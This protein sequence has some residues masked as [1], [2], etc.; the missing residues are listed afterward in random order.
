MG[1][2]KTV[3]RRRLGTL[4]DLMEGTYGAMKRSVEDRIS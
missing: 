1:K 3:G 4:D 2:K